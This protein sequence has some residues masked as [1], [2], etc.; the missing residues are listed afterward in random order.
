[1]IRLKA[2]HCF[3]GMRE[4]NEIEKQENERAGNFIPRVDL[5][6]R[7]ILLEESLRHGIAI[8]LKDG[9]NLIKRNM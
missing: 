4:Y 6:A 5:K 9:F 8:S 2:I 3:S 1:M 7:E